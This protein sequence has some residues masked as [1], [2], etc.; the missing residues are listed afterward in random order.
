[1]GEGNRGWE[2]RSRRAS[3]GRRQLIEDVAFEQELTGTGEGRASQAGEQHWQTSRM[4]SQ[5]ALEVKQV[6]DLASCTAPG[7]WRHQWLP[8]SA[9]RGDAA[10]CC[11]PVTVLKDLRPRGFRLCRVNSSDTSRVPHP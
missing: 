3:W 10:T 11:F 8:P 6:F 7:T 5:C 9:R 4:A 2:R 1:M